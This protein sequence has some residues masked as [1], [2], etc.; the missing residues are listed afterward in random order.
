MNIRRLA[1]AVTCG[2]LLLSCDRGPAAP[3][4]NSIRYARSIALEPVFPPAFQQGTGAAG[5]ATFTEVRVLF[6]RVTGVTA[7]DTLIAF[8]A[9]AD[10][11][12]LN[13]A[14]PLSSD[15]PESG[16]ALTVTLF[17]INAQG[18]TVF[19]GGP[20]PVIAM[21]SSRGSGGA[22]A[23]PLVYVGAPAT[24]VG[25]A[26]QLVIT[27]QPVSGIAGAAFGLVATVEDASGNAVASF[28]GAVSLALGA[29][30]GGSALGGSTTINAVAGVAKFTALSLTRAFSGYT[31]VASASGVGS[32]TS[33][34]FNISPAAPSNLSITSGNNQSGLIGLLLGTPIAVTVADAY[35][36]LVPNVPVTWSVLTGSGSLTSSTTQTNAAGVAT[37]TWT[38][39]SLVG[40]QTVSAVAGNLTAV[41]FNAIGLANGIAGA[42]TKLLM[43]AVASSAVAGSAI[44]AIVVTAVDAAGNVV[45]AFTGPVSLAL[46]SNPGSTSLGGT[47]TVNA[48]AG[49]ATFTSALLTKAASGYTLVAS[50]SG[51]TPATS[52][53]FSIIP[54]E[55]ATVS[56]SGGNNQSSVIGLL[57]GTPLAVTVADAYSNLVPNVPVTWSVL[58]GGG[59]LGSSSSQTNASGVATNTWTLGSL[60]GT[61]A[62]RAVAGGLTNAPATFSAS[63]LASGVSE[64]ATKLVMSAVPSSAIAGSAISAIVVT[65]VAAGGNAVTSFAQPV[66]LALGS[67]PGSTSLGGTTIVNAVAGVATFSS[68]TLTKAASGYTLVASAS[69]LASAT[70]SAFSIVAAAAASLTKAGGDNQSGLLSILGIL[71]PTPL[72]VLVTDGYG[73]PVSNANVS[74]AVTLGGAQLGGATSQTGA[75]GIATNTLT[76]TGLVTGV[77]HVTATV[78]GITTSVVFGATG[79]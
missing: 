65:A 35:S 50:A 38:L 29:S 21:P 44:G 36:N 26:T 27:S 19:R 22:V 40:A 33:S 70:S 52:S 49:V 72:S 20:V 8:P 67:N 73:N 28:T 16:E 23:I 61:Q 42:A 32:S 71:L 39:G 34:A 74:W 53:A 54:A 51:L 13:F 60:V 12:A 2:L 63:G 10:S 59:S 5:V 41:T 43:S 79:L 68:A 7:L 17:C 24:G 48:V 6:L 4:G 3:D 78:A 9:T 62:V 15:A 47:T 14:I 75:N 45:T 1:L 25:S 57:L 37:N 64:A 31:I 11:I 55:P 18:D 77:R 58:T 76:L 69:G 46:G 66:S 56:I 30:A